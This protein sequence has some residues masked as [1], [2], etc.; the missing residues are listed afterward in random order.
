MELWLVGVVAVIIL[1]ALIMLG[2]PIAYTFSI[3]GFSGLWWITGLNSALAT[4]KGNAYYQ[5][6]DY[7]WAVFPLFIV[8]GVVA[9]EGG[10]TGDAF[11]ATE[12]WLG[13]FRGGLAFATTAAGTLFAAVCGS[14]L[15]ASVTMAK[16]AWP[17]MRKAKYNPALSLGS[18]LCSG[19]LAS[20]IPPSIVFVVYAMLAEESVGKLFIGGIVPGLVLAVMMIITVQ[21][22][23]MMD[24]K[25]APPSTKQPWSEKFK[26]LKGTWTILSLI[27]LVMGGLWSGIFTANEAAGIGAG[28]AMAIAMMKKRLTWT[29]TARVFADAAAMSA[30]IFLLLT[31]VQIF[32]NFLTVTNMPT[33]LA[34]WVVSLHLSKT[35]VLIFILVIYAILGVPLELPPILMLTLPIFIPLLDGM[36][37]NKIWFGILS[38]MTVGLAGITPPVG[39]PMFLVHGVV[40]KDGV[41]LN[42]VF[43]GCWV[44][45]IPTLAALIACLIWPQLTL[46]LPGTMYGK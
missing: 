13:R 15:A 43:N 22:W 33:M 18:I 6:A 20:L 5:V 17:E 38:T 28:G 35:V 1:I 37:I 29:G 34:D 31:G 8:M 9:G 4:L 30:N 46:W 19:S 24:P 26:A 39:A 42:T 41:S 3:V 45:C 7:V 44:F 32:N 36:G 12:K 10:L 25:A 16:V 11:G 23:I 21:V 14:S 40:K 27:I 2:M